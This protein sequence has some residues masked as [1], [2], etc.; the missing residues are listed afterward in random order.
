MKKNSLISLAESFIA[1]LI[2]KIE[3]DQAILYGSVVNNEFDEESDIDIFIDSDKKNEKKIINLLELFEKT[4]IF[5]KYTL[6]GTKNKISLKVGK[7][8]EWGGLKRSFISNGIILYGKYKERPN[9]LKAYIIFSIDYKKLKRKDKIKLWRKLYG[10]K[11][12]VGKKLYEIRGLVKFKLGGG[13]IIIEPENKR[14][15]IDLLKIYKVDYK[16]YEIWS[17]TIL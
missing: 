6:A 10:Y 3:I 15:I 12:K 7:I 8:D 17:D 2:D 5:E 4:D 13:C 14:K 16:L 1:F 9:E 11:Q